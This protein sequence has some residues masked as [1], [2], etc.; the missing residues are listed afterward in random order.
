MLDLIISGGTVVDGTGVPGKR[1]DVGIA[2][3]RVVTVGE[4]DDSAS[5]T[6]D[7]DGLVLSRNGARG[8]SDL[9]G[10]T[11]AQFKH[12]ATSHSLSWGCR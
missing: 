5:R 7:A 4:V 10:T 11:K 8:E 1:A 12:D 3:G 6:I 9:A 2:G